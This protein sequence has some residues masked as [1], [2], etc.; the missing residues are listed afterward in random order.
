MI[1]WTAVR[2]LAPRISQVSALY[3]HLIYPPGGGNPRMM[4]NS[5]LCLGDHLLSEPSFAVAFCFLSPR[6]GWSYQY[7]QLRRIHQRTRWRCQASPLLLF[8]WMHHLFKLPT[9][10]LV[11]EQQMCKLKILTACYHLSLMGTVRRI[12]PWEPCLQQVPAFYMP[13]TLTLV[14]QLLPHLIL[15]IAEHTQLMQLSTQVSH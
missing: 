2:L 10:Q 8:I 9:H 5:L 13:T 3:G 6:W 15:L 4:Y 1:C 11:L 12:L 14:G 7:L